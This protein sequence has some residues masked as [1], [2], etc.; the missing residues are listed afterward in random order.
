MP[1]LKMLNRK[2][3]SLVRKQNKEFEKQELIK[4]K[5]EIENKLKEL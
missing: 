1:K 2:D 3:A 4:Q 5:Q